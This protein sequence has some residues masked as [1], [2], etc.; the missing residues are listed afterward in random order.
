MI[1]QQSLFR[2]EQ[3]EDLS[4]VY[5]GGSRVS[6]IALQESVRR[7]MMNVIFG[8]NSEESLARLNPNGS[9]ERM[10]QGSCQVKMDGS[11]D[12]FCETWPKWGIVLDGVAY[13]Q[14]RLEPAIEEKEWRL[15]PTPTANLWMGYDYTTASRFHGKK[16]AKRPNGAR[17]SR[18][19]NNFEEIK[20]SYIP[21]TTNRLNPLLLERMMGFP[22]Q[23]TEIEQSVTQ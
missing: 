12:V 6:R 13:Q 10:Y 22:D 3:E 23:W 21:G 18:F 1:Y 17:H 8:L 9:W 14:L 5:R 19:L 7:L 4:I 16:T 15:L 20:E 11:L 2:E